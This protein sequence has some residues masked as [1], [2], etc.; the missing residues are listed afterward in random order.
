MKGKMNYRLIHNSMLWVTMVLFIA[1]SSALFNSDHALAADPSIR[2]TLN[3]YTILRQDTN[4]IAYIASIMSDQGLQETMVKTYD[5]KQNLSKVLYTVKN[6]NEDSP[7]LSQVQFSPDGSAVTFLASSIIWPK[8]QLMPKFISKIQSIDLKTG[9]L[10]T[11]LIKKEI[12]TSFAFAP[13]GKSIFITMGIQSKP[14]AK[15]WF[16]FNITVFEYNLSSKQTVQRTTVKTDNRSM[17][18]LKISQDGK[19]IYT[20][21]TDPRKVKNEDEAFY[22]PQQVYRFPLNNVHSNGVQVSPTHP[23]NINNFS[24]NDNETILYYGTST[25]YMDSAGKLDFEIFA[26]YPKSK[27]KKQIT[28]LGTITENPIAIGK[29]LFFTVDTASDLIYPNPQLTVMNINTGK[30]EIIVLPGLTTMDQTNQQVKQK[31]AE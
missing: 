30:T 11:L 3:E 12:I 23:R 1:T 7:E 5:R 29:Q 26:Y 24:W 8:G 28:S 19:F 16:D 13:D 17:S 22:V 20:T 6:N 4:Q 9:K 21:M 18:F 27:T 14:A 15:Q 10:S 31:I 25:D 2:T